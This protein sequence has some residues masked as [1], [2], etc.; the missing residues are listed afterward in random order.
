[1]GLGYG[2]ETKVHHAKSQKPKANFWW[3]YQK[4]TGEKKG[5]IVGEKHFQGKNGK[6]VQHACTLNL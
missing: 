3:R 6:K 5:R 2:E 1:M 4:L